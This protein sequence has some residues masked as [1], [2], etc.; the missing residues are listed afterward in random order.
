MSPNQ[1]NPTNNTLQGQYAGFISRFLAV[2]IDIIVVI[3]TVSVVGAVIS[4]LLSFF[5]LTE[6]F[7]NL[8]QSIS[9]QGS[10]VRAFTAVS[11]VGTI[12]FLYIVIAWTVTS[13]KT[14]G[15]GLIGLRIVP[16]DGK[17]ITLLRATVRYIAFWISVLA[18]GLGIFWILVSDRRQGWH[19]KLAKTCVIYDWPARED[20]LIAENFRN[21]LQYLKH[22][23]KRLKE[24]R[25]KNKELD[26]SSTIP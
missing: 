18:F 13:G 5:G 22:T 11:G 14:I 1:T 3:I 6:F 4:L 15:K 19:D 16:M 26:S 17:R 12:A 21:R 2:L 7:D 23:R 24:R 20:V 8:E 25:A 9:I 10:I